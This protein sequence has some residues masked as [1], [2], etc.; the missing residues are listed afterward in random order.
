VASSNQQAPDLLPKNDC[1]T[2][3]ALQPG[4][5]FL[6]NMSFPEGPAAI[7]DSAASREIFAE[8][9][10]DPGQLPVPLSPGTRRTI[11]HSEA[12]EFS[13]SALWEGGGGGVSCRG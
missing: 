12:E 2:L 1:P 13:T 6:R 4:D 11:I 10:Q 8:I 7:Q 5:E 9:L 3:F